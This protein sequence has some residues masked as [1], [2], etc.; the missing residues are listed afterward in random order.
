M[1]R[2]RADNARHLA[3]GETLLTLTLSSLKEGG[4]GIKYRF[5]GR[6]AL[7]PIALGIAQCRL[8]VGAGG[9]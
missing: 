5:R 7:H 6:F 4:E 3:G 1:R 9:M 2:P 8:L